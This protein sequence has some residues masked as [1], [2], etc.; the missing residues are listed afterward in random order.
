MSYPLL[1]KITYVNITRNLSTAPCRLASTHYDALGITP[2]ATQG[3]VKAAYYRMSKM[4]H[5]DRNSNIDAPQKFRNVTAAYEVL[6]DV[7]LRRLYDKG[8]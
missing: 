1:S 4:Y 5:P 2:K 7:R 8:N 6:G 3:E